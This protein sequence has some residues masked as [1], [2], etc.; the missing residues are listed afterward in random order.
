MVDVQI[1]G[2]RYHVSDRVRDYATD[3]F[4]GLSRFCEGLSLI[5]VTIHE[6]DNHKHG[7]RVDVDMHLPHGKDVIA[8]DTEETVYAAIDVV[9]DKCAKQLRRDHDRRSGHHRSDRIK[10][11]V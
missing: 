9:V 7:Y 3:K 2:V 10:A 1:S 5:H 8:H 11:R 6:E 4:T